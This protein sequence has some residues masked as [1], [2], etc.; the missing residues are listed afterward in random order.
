MKKFDTHHFRG[1]VGEG[2]QW[3][4]CGAKL[5]PTRTRR[6]VALATFFVPP[7]QTGARQW[8]DAMDR[9]MV[10]EESKHSAYQTSDSSFLFASPGETW[11]QLP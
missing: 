7:Y 10:N 11:E 1:W 4:S 9:A 8:F 6:G 5:Q 2:E 3:A